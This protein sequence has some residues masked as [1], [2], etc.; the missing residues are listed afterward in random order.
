MEKQKNIE[1][2]L[3]EASAIASS[4]CT[5]SYCIGQ[6]NVDLQYDNY[7]SDVFRGIE[8]LG[9]LLDDKLTAISCAIEGNIKEVSA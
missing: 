6:T 5:I 9:N 3:V 4:I 2:L 8:F 7:K 1:D